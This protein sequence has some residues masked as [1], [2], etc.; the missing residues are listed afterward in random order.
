MKNLH[1][2]SI[3]PIKLHLI[4]GFGAYVMR[5]LDIDDTLRENLHLQIMRPFIDKD[6]I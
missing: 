1:K 6:I 3:Q 4:E 2:I 5:R